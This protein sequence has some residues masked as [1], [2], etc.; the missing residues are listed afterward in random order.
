[1]AWET[2]TALNH[3]DLLARLR[4]FLTGRATT[5]TPVPTGSGNGVIS[6][7][8]TTPLSIT[9]TW[10]LVCTAVAANGGTFSVTGSISGVQTPA[11]VGVPYSNTLL[12]FLI[13]D[14][15]VDFALLD[16]FVFTTTRGQMSTDGNAW[17]LKRSTASE[18]QVMGKGTGGT[19]QIYVNVRTQV[20]VGSDIYN[21]VLQ[22]AA[23]YNPASTIDDQPGKSPMIGLS[24]WND[25]MQYWIVA[26]G[27]RFIIVA[28]V[29]TYYVS[30]YCGL[31]LPFGT[32]NQYPYPLFIG[33]NLPNHSSA[34]SAANYSW[35]TDYNSNYW[36]P[37][38][39]HPQHEQVTTDITQSVLYWLDGSWIDFMNHRQGVFM[40]VEPT[41]N[42]YNMIAPVD[43]AWV[44][45]N[46]DGSYTL[47]PHTLVTSKPSYSLTGELDGSYYVSGFSNGSENIVQSGGFDH[48]VV[49][50]VSR[51][52]VPDFAAIKL[53]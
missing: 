11:D 17:E 15:T 53:E 1:M 48:L 12:S 21:F 5:T 24:L 22:G 44:R 40:T 20:N 34:Y 52:G 16:Q 38:A 43:R 46:I 39:A 41:L 32:P 28:K 14:G 37:R 3:T 31:I 27:R 36:S 6:G 29:S 51:N 4:R 2:G 7:L 47:F 33:G 13:N 35:L 50:N 45:D 19:E 30:C 25:P 8:D 42:T 9:E 23:G 10:T 18:L 49:Q 26:N